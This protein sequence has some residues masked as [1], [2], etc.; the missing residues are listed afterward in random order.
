MADSRRQDIIEKVIAAMQTING[1]GSFV[2]SI[3]TNVAD[4][5]LN[6]QEEDLPA[7]SVCDTD[8]SFEPLNDEI[9]MQST[10]SV[11]IRGFLKATDS[12]LRAIEGRKVIAD[13]L[14]AVKANQKWTNLAQY[15][16]LKQAGFVLADD[17]FSIAAVAVNIEIIYFAE[18]FSPYG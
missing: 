9:S 11:Q 8:E 1:A 6:W 10:L 4:W 7:L 13:I 18:R 16:Q 5:R 12:T 14:T 17:A 3:G 2:T 15:T